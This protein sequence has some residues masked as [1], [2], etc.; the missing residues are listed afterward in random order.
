M[1]ENELPC[2]NLRNLNLGYNPLVFE[3]SS[4][5]PSDEFISNLV[6]FLGIAQKL[7]HIDISGMNLGRDY[8]PEKFQFDVENHISSAPIMSL[9]VALTECPYL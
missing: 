7:N 4:D 5:G 8:N 3:E 1:D 6:S 2:R 9:V